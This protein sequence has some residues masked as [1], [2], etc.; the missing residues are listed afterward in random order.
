MPRAVR[1]LVFGAP[2][3]T[4][5]ARG[6][7]ARVQEQCLFPLAAVLPAALAQDAPIMI[8]YNGLDRDEF[9]AVGNRR[10]RP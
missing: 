9:R 2:P 5:A 4:A 1:S 10:A 7:N 3:R 6:T 8:G